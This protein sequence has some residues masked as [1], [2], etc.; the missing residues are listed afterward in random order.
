MAG[1]YPQL[2]LGEVARTVKEKRGKRGE[3]KQ[4]SPFVG[5]TKTGFLTWGTAAKCTRDGKRE[6]KSS[7]ESNR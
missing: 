7:Q 2:D 4:L 3:G 6:E 1:Y 5:V